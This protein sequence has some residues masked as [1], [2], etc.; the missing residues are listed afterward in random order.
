[1]TSLRTAAPI[2]LGLVI[3]LTY[4]LVQGMASDAPRHERA[5]AL[6][7]ITFN[8]A[9]LQRDVLKARAGSLL[10]YDPLVQSV[11][12]LTSASA[13]LAAMRDVATGATRIRIDRK[14]ADVAKVVRDQEALVETFK[15][16][17]ALLQNS[18]SYFNHLSGSLTVAG[19]QSAEITAEVGVLTA[20]MFRFINAPRQETARE[21]EA[22]LD[23]LARSSGNSRPMGDVRLLIAH[24]RLIVATLPNVD[25]IVARLQAVPTNDLTR[26]LQDAYLEAHEQ[27]ALRSDL[28]MALLYAVALV[29]VAYA[30]HLFIRLRA[31][32]RSLRDRLD[33]EGLIAAISTQFINLP[34]E[35]VGSEVK[36]ALAQ[37][38]EHAGMGGACLLI[39]REGALDDTRSCFHQA[40]AGGDRDCTAI[41][42]LARSRVLRGH[43]RQGCIAVADVAALPDGREKTS[44]Q[45]LHIGSWLC[46]PLKV[47]GELL[48]F[49]IFYGPG[50][51]HWQDDDVALL[52]TVGEI[53]ANAIA[54]EGNEMAREA[55]QT[56]LNQSQRLEAIGTLAGGIAH[57]FNN[58]LGAIR[59]YGEMALG[60]LAADSRAQRHVQQIM[61]AGERAQDVI[62]QI[63][64]FGRRRERRYRPIR[65]EPAV[66]EAADLLRASFPAT[67]SVKMHLVAKDAVISGDPTELQQVVMNL[68]TNAVQAMGGCGVLAIGLDIVEHSQDLGLSHG[69]LPAGRYVRLVVRDTGH[70]IDQAAM[71]RIFEPF[72]TTK[73]VGKGTGLGLSTVLGIV[74]AHG[75]TI[76][77][78]SR[79]AEGTTFEVYFPLS[80]GTVSESR[81]EETAA[82]PAPGGRGETVLIVDDDRPLMLLGE[83]MLASLGYEPVGFDRSKAALSAFRAAPQRFALVLTD[84]IMPDVTGTELAEAMHKVRPD[85]PI[86]LMTG[87]GYPI[88]ANRLNSAGIR[89]V[90][91]KPLLSRPLAEC[92]ARQI[93]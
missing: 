53:F 59:G 27:A 89:E 30:V 70:G 92:L 56:R 87:Y 17:N 69:N 55:L 64:A 7:A 76:H 72:F 10:N 26:S 77:V 22:S 84:E 57:E 12:G 34:R 14:I 25:I 91:K 88:P 37:L 50:K 24:G 35:A 28:F 68:G 66:A 32:A 51:R 15:S 82:A 54:R 8:N 5:D 4:L 65:A 36:R 49:L 38:T 46:L 23:R 86:V 48:G 13:N 18:L 45:D 42:D 93:G 6:Q 39:L 85:L 1:M 79:I 63:L 19:A 58:I 83:E 62:E 90:L 40:S 80:E 67:L 29:L 20:A 47:R 61:N 2:A 71:Q 3:V 43:E 81:I 31:N 44:L 74:G 41:F 11:T 16:D 9:A 73:P 60:T 78:D 75:G 52:R 33:F 21:V